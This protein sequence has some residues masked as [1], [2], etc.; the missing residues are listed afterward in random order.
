MGFETY[1]DDYLLTFL[2]WHITAAH[3]Q[4][5]KLFPKDRVDCMHIFFFSILRTDILLGKTWWAAGDALLYFKGDTSCLI[6]NFFYF[7]L[8]QARGWWTYPHLLSLL[9]P[10]LFLLTLQ[11]PAGWSPMAVMF[12]LCSVLI[13]A[14]KHSGRIKWIHIF[15]LSGEKG[16]SWACSVRKSLW[17]DGSVPLH[18]GQRW[19]Y[20]SQIF[21]Y[22][23]IPVNF[24]VDK[25]QKWRQTFAVSWVWT[26]LTNAN[27][28]TF[29]SVYLQQQMETSEVILSEITWWWWKAA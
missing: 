22:D 26:L 14:V 16:E 4:S 24:I 11:N 25:C 7:S 15:S 9:S 3:Q 19:C 1:L 21:I 29:F 20:Y 23:L 10:S 6:Y 12:V 5:S 18:L 8:F 2:P 17:R 13:W 27:D 28:K